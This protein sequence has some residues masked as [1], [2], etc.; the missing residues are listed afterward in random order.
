VNRHTVQRRGSVRPW[1]WGLLVVLLL[2][3]AP[4]QA[5]ANTV[6]S[7]PLLAALTLAAGLLLT[8]PRRT[9]WR[10]P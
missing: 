9:A 7:S 4:G 10:R 1:L 5:A 2:A 3:T 8:R 6:L